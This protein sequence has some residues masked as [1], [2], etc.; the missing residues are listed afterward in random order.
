MRLWDLAM[1]M[2][3]V[4]LLLMGGIFVGIAWRALS[5]QRRR[6]HADNAMIPLRDDVPAS[7]GSDR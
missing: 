6:E 4:E 1:A 7:R 3:P 5:P 2:R